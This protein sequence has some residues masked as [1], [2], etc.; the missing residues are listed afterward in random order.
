MCI[1]DSHRVVDA[2]GG[3]DQQPVGG[4]GDALEALHQAQ[5]GTGIQAGPFLDAAAGRQDADGLGAWFL[6]P[7]P[8][9]PDP[10]KN[11]MPASALKNKK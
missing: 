6:Y 7:F 3:V 4:G 10:H 5:F 9:P 1:R 2:R 11:S 8:E